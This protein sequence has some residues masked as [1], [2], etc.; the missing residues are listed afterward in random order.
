M[1][2]RS[3][4]PEDRT[5]SA[6]VPFGALDGTLLMSMT[7]DGD[8]DLVPHASGQ[9]LALDPTLATMVACS[10]FCDALVDADEAQRAGTST[11]RGYWADAYAATRGAWGSKLWRLDRAKPTRATAQACE[12][13]AKEALDWMIAE[14]IADSIEASAVIVS[15]M[16]GAA[17]ELTVRIQRP[18]HLVAKYQQ[19]WE[20]TYAL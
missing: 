1:T 15:G 6:D 18:A 19:I 7:A 16:G 14:G 13:A 3:S 4:T 5:A 8:W 2:A 11:R 12:V 20:A 17:L 9:G 10:L